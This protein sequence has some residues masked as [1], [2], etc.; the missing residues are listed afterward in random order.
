MALLLKE[1]R[2]TRAP[3]TNFVQMT[4]APDGI[5]RLKTRSLSQEII[6]QGALGNG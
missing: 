1:P 4:K 2:S 6:L 3:H 5:K